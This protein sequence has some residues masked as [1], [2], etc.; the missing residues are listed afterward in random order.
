MAPKLEIKKRRGHQQGGMT[1]IEIIVVL[2]IFSILSGVAMFNYKGF[3]DQ[4]DIRNL[5]SDIALKV[6]KAQNDSRA[7]A[8]TLLAPLGWKPSYGLF[9]IAN[10]D[11]DNNF[12]Y[13]ADYN[14]NGIF[15]NTGEP[16]DCNGECLEK[17]TM[18][19]GNRI[20]DLLITSPGLNGST[21]DTT[22]VFSRINAEPVIS[23][24][25]EIF[26]N[27][28]VQITVESPKG[29]K[30]LITISPSGKMEVK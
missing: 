28:E 23:S 20:S 18:T 30:A 25:W 11:L 6:I 24:D 15:N 12:I 4:V 19:K 8:W 17:V 22:L 2:G 21:S 16:M 14:N 9:F 1:Y 3:Q 26:P 10:A 7:G 5:G 29:L 27:A 13:F